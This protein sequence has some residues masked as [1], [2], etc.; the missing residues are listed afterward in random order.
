VGTEVKGVQIQAE[1]ELEAILEM[2]EIAKDRPVQEEEQAVVDME[3]SVEESVE[4]A[5]E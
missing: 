4:L 2:V 1:V 3:Q 5:V